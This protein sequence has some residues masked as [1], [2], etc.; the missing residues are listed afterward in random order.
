MG[1]EFSDVWLR[2]FKDGKIIFRSGPFEDE[3][4]ASLRKARKAWLHHSD[5]HDRDS[6][7]YNETN[8]MCC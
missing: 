7:S 6:S 4:D 1:E 2:V 3:L 8:Q 5:L